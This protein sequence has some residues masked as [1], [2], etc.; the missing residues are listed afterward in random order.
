MRI[1]RR[2]WLSRLS[3]GALFGALAWTSVIVLAPP[4]TARR[5]VLTRGFVPMRMLGHALGV[6]FGTRSDWVLLG[7]SRLSQLDDASW[8]QGL[9]S[10]TNIALSGSAA[11]WWRA[12]LLKWPPLASS[13]AR[14]VLWL[15][16][17]DMLNWP[18]TA[19]QAADDVIALAELVAARVREV[20]VLD[21]IPV[22]LNAL[23][24]ARNASLAA[25]IRAF[26]S[27]LFAAR[28]ASSRIRRVALFARFADANGGPAPA[29]YTDGLHP[30]ARGHA[31]IVRL[32]TSH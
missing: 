15:G 4:D 29:L 10:P 27:R 19:E 6:P 25:E 32:V 11:V 9:A 17:N 28:F 18:R 7:D 2:R 26:N 1:L 23:T 31:L 14:V 5:F 21:Q 16:V 20:V 24:D 30:N 22:K 8:P 13:R 12:L 3:M